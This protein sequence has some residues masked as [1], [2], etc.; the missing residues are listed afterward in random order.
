MK[1]QDGRD[2]PPF[3]EATERWQ[4]QLIK[5]AARAFMH[6][7]CCVF[8]GKEQGGHSI[9]VDFACRI[10]ALRYDGRETCWMRK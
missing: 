10:S 5:K 7:G 1:R 2:W 8:C 4:K 3:A 6:R 9:V